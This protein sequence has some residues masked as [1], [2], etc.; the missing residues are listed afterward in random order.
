MLHRE[1]VTDRRRDMCW[2]LR[3]SDHQLDD[4]VGGCGIE[5]AGPLRVFAYQ[6]CM[7]YMSAVVL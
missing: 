3:R 1:M 4:V 6:P 5:K 7:H 2:E